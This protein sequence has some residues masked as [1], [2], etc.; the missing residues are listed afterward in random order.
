MLLPFFKIWGQLGYEPLI[1][2]C[3][4]LPYHD[5]N[6]MKF[7]LAVGCGIPMLVITVCYLKIYIKVKQ[8]GQNL[9][10]ILD[11][12]TSDILQEQINKRERQ[13]TKV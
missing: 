7:I 8:T 13:L 3:T 9:K 4:I 1:F 6:P 11:K 12:G 5:K 10:D 2:S